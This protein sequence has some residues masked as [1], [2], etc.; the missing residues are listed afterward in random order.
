VNTDLRASLIAS[1]AAALLSAIVG[2]LSA[3]AFLPLLLRAV[4][5][6]LL[7]GGIVFGAFAL[8][9]RFM[10]ELFGEA[11]ESPSTDSGLGSAVNIVLPAEEPELGAEKEE[12]DSLESAEPGAAAPDLA[13]SPESVPGPSK[14]AES[15]PSRP[16]PAAYEDDSDFGGESLLDGPEEA[17]SAGS[18]ELP[19]F[20][21]SPLREGLEDLD[22]LP[23]LDSLSDSFAESPSPAR[24]EDAD[25]RRGAHGFA[26]G[27]AS[28]SGAA[29]SDPA[30]LAQAVR[31]LLKRDQ[32]G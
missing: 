18:A 28:A 4:L 22:V 9:R 11:E 10:P 21:D 20:S 6:G 8:A 7:I 17:S 12:L 23:D 24:N 2:A 13:A 15:A 16:A 27:K 1:G 5:G 26:G 3:V 30:L 14:G 32:K 29:G 19:S 31:T 25:E